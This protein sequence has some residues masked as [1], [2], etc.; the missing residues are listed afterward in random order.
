MEVGGDVLDLLGV[1]GR[2]GVDP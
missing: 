2:E 1:G